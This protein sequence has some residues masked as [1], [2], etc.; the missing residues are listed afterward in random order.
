MINATKTTRN[1]A[2]LAVLAAQTACSDAMGPDGGPTPEPRVTYDLSV[3]TR[4]INVEGSCDE[5]IFG[6]QVP[7]EF[8]YRIEVREG[9]QL[10]GSQESRGYNSVS[11]ESFQ[12][13]R[14][15]SINFSDRTFSW[16]DIPG[17]RDIEIT[18]RAAEW[19]GLRKDSRM[20]NRGVSKR[21]PFKAGTA[22][23]R[24]GLG[25]DAEK[26]ALGLYYDATWTAVATN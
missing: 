14:T 25:P 5:D 13:N 24:V 15:T 21:V 11:G 26:C 23:H 8:Q 2:V 1:I 7:G 12:R 6:S 4:Y 20:A 18:F 16:R 10:R 9:N 3:K 22:T 17:T 19:D